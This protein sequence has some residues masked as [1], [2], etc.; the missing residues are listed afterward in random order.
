MA[1]NENSVKKEH[2]TSGGEHR[3]GH[4]RGGKGH[5]GRHGFRP[6]NGAENKEGAPAKVQ[7]GKPHTPPTEKKPE[8]EKKKHPAHDGE[9]RG[10]QP[11]RREEQKGK[12][13]PARHGEESRRSEEPKREQRG[14]HG[15]PKKGAVGRI[16]PVQEYQSA[17][18]KAFAEAKDILL[19][20]EKER[21]E[22]VALQEDDSPKVEVVGV[23]FKQTG[24]IYY[25]A[26]SGISFD[27]GDGVIVETSRGQEYGF[28][29]MANRM[30]S[31]KEIVQPLKDV[32]RKATAEDGVKHKKN[33]EMEKRAA[34]V[35]E[36]LVAK[37]KLVMSLTE[38]EYTFDNSKL[39]FYFT[40]DGRVD[41][42]ELVKDLAGVFRTR[43]ELRQIGV[44][45]EAKLLGGI[46][47]C[48]MPFCCNRFLPDFVQ[49]SIKMAKEQNLSLSSSKISGNC[50]SLMC[51]LRYEQDVY[52]REY[53][54]FPR[55]D[56]MVITAQGKGVVAESNFINGK[57]KVRMDGDGTAVYKVFTRDEV[58]VIGKAKAHNDEPV[59][60]ELKA[61]ED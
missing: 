51:C 52:E 16:A 38:V 6:K 46:G 24:K 36:D 37:H 20:A 17:E 7:E 27:A 3:Q 43:I 57:I 42:R 11:H 55:P 45:D 35:W 5:K 58:K 41:F 12:K 29:A 4:H 32:L 59:D 48:G 2:N 28:V 21:S 60:K 14:R 13:A 22:G 23:R 19:E 9:K 18:Q 15:E 39:I 56:M 40:A 53:T 26:P 30:V 10:H 34:A 50:G 44:R 8:G 25:F 33:K 49:V 1:E 61:L 54:T 31:E 47:V